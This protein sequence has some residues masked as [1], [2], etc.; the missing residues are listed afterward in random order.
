MGALDSVVRA[1]IYPG[2]GI[3]RVGNSPDEFFIGPEL[4]HAILSVEGGFKDAQ[5][6]LKRQAA[7]FRLYGFDAEGK[8]VA[9]LTSPAAEIVWTVHVAN[10]KAAWYNFETPMDIPSAIPSERRNPD[11]AGAER[12]K[13]R[14]DPGPLSISG[15]NRRGSGY[16]FDKGTFLEVPVYL[17]ELSTDEL[18]R[19]LFLGGHGVSGTPF[20]QNSI[21]T[22]ANNRAWY[23]D[24]SDGPVSA[25]V[26]IS[27]RKIPV[28]PA[29]V[30]TAPPN[31]APDLKSNITMYDV[32]F[33]LYQGLLFDPFNK[34]SFTQDILPIL[35][36]FCEL[37]WVNF[38]Y[39]LMFG[40]GAPYDFTR[41][42]Y[43]RRLATKQPEFAESRRQV[44]NLFRNPAA[45]NLEI[46]QWPQNYGDD[47]QIPPSAPG[48]MLSVTNTQY[49]MLQKWAAG[50]FEDDWNPQVPEPSQRVEDYPLDQQPELLTRA[51]LA[52]CS[53]GPFHPGCELPWIMRH[54]WVY[55]APFRIRPRAADGQ[56]ERDYGDVLTPQV[57][58]GE[59]GPMYAS[60]PGDLTRWMAVPWQ[61]DTAGCRAGYTP[62]WDPFLPTFWPARVPNHVFT[63]DNYQAFLRAASPEDRMKAFD[64]RATWLRFLDGGIIEQMRQ[65]TTEF[66]KLGVVVRKTLDSPPP[67]FPPVVFVEEGAA[68]PAG[69]PHDKN[70]TAS[71]IGRTSQR[72]KAAGAGS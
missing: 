50:D 55:C 6:A 35:R 14:I 10:T 32:I 48:S 29:W 40:W 5:G 49:A 36:R 26:T 42:D 16:R 45:P 31:Y 71:P 30:V 41:S 57:A 65:M 54:V 20:P 24:T 72:R 43:L 12:A 68:F 56:P 67:G 8:V 25:E 53:G 51:A 2:I 18:G 27:G 22:Y 7:R 28:D 70:R 37:Q 44:L 58:V 39:F 64:T 69:A 11:Y 47:V 19:L 4:P 15:V 61:T 9:E 63:S 62:A 3:A 21:A 23:D 13:L 52:F 33:D 17:G 66:G 46:V 60:R 34:V 59:N 1:A 38:G